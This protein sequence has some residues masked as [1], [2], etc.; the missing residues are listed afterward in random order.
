MPDVRLFVSDDTDLPLLREALGGLSADAYGQVFVETDVEQRDE[1]RRPPGVAVT[2]LVRDPD[3]DDPRP[4]GSLAAV[5]AG[6]WASEWMIGS[7]S[8]SR[9]IFVWVGPSVRATVQALI[10][11]QCC[12]CRRDQ[13]VEHGPTQ[14]RDDHS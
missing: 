11:E 1:L 3:A 8:P 14:R 13:H 4:A 7:A 12:P 6:A 2:W 5:V 9:R 10:E